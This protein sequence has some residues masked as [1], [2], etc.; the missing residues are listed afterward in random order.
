MSATSSFGRDIA[1]ASLRRCRCHVQEFKRALNLPDHVD[2]NAGIA[3]GR[4]DVPMPEQ[5]LD[6][7]NVDT[8]FEQMGRETMSQRVD[9]DRLAEPGGLGRSPACQLQR[10]A[11]SLVVM[12]CGRET[13]SA[14]A[15]DAANSREECRAAAWTEWYSDPC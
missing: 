11:L 9:G 4:L 12:D 6:H 3:H 5:V 7:A 10:A 2:R 8:L 13:A 1:S 14:R 15:G